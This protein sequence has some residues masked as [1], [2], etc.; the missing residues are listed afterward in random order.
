MVSKSTI[1]HYRI[2]NVV[3]SHAGAYKTGVLC[4]S[5]SLST[6]RRSLFVHDTRVWLHQDPRRPCT[7]IASRLARLRLYER[8]AEGLHCTV[9]FRPSLLCDQLSVIDGGARRCQ[10]QT[11]QDPAAFRLSFSRHIGTVLSTTVT[12]VP[13]GLGSILH[14]RSSRL[15]S[16]GSKQTAP[17]TGLSKPACSYLCTGHP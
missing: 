7:L 3:S 15:K 12:T 1:K 4:S 6:G 10:N 5:R 9:L 16:Q 14:N 2:L 13:C 17:M 8:L 11:R